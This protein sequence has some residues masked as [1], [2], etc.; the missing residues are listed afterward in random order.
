MKGRPKTW[1]EKRRGLNPA[2]E[3]P[4]RT[5]S[6]VP[7]C[8]RYF[9]KDMRVTW[10]QTAGD[11]IVSGLLTTQ[12]LIPLESYC[13]AVDNMRKT[14]RDKRA[15]TT[16]KTAAVKEQRIAAETLGLTPAAHSKM[17][18]PMAAAVDNADDQRFSEIVN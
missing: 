3:V 2:N 17:K 8:P 10:K 1:D 6:K 5:L 7:P 13:C 9:S 12:S 18:R 14:M 4:V 15:K 11:L 16:T